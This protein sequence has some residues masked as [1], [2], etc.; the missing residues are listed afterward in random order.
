MTCDITERC[1]E[2]EDVA[3]VNCHTKVCEECE[4]GEGE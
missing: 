4:R 1:I 3:L 2:C